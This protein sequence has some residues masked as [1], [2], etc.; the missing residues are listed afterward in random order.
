MKPGVEVHCSG[1]QSG[2]G[3]SGRGCVC[4]CVCVRPRESVGLGSD[5]CRADRRAQC[6]LFPLSRGPL[7]T[8]LFPAPTAAPRAC[9]PITRARPIN[10]LTDISRYQRCIE[11]FVIY[12]QYIEQTN[13]YAHLQSFFELFNKLL[14]EHHSARKSRRERVG[15]AVRHCVACHSQRQRISTSK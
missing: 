14:I 5:S 11:I 12:I 6:S 3:E 13:M 4:L 2:Y 9:W 7:D 1:E 8:W 15:M 10:S